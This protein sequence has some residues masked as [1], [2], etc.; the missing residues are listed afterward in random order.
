MNVEILMNKLR[1]LNPQMAN[2]PFAQSALEAVVKGDV[3]S[4]ETIAKNLMNSLG[5]DQ[6][7]FWEQA[8]AWGKQVGLIK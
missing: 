6:N 2:T 7:V 8:L 4:C 1:Q 5:V 3:S